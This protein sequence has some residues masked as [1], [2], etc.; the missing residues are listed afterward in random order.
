[1]YVHND[2]NHNLILSEYSGGN[3]YLW[4][5][6][7]RYCLDVGLVYNPGDTDYPT[8]LHTLNKHLETHK[9]SMVFG[10]FNI[11]L[12]RKD[13]R[14]RAYTSLICEC[15][16]KPLNCIKQKH[17][18]R[19]TSKTKTL[20]DHVLTNLKDTDFHIATVD[21]ALFDHKQ[22]FVQ[23]NKHKS[24]PPKRTQY[25]ATDYSKLKNYIKESPFV[26]KDNSYNDLE[27]Y[28]HLSIQNCKVTKVKVSNPPQ[29][30]WINKEVIKDLNYRNRLWYELKLD[31]YNKGLQSKFRTSRSKVRQK[32][33]QT[34]NEF[35]LKQFFA[36]KNNPKKVWSLINTLSR[37][38][39]RSSCVPPKLKHS[40]GY[41]IEP[42]QVCESF[43]NFFSTVGLELAKNIPFR[44]HND[45]I[46]IDSH[47]SN[48]ESKLE[49]FRPCTED[50]IVKIIDKLD[51]KTSAG[52][53]NITTKDIK[54]IG[55][56]MAGHFSKCFNQLFIEGKFPDT[57]K[58]AKVSPIYKSGPRTDPSNYRPISVLP[59]ISKILERIIYSRLDQYLTSINFLT[60]RQY[61]F[62]SRSSTLAATIDL[63]T[64]IK[65][66]IDQRKIV[67]GVFIDL[68]KA[69]DTVNHDLLIRKLVNVGIIGSALDMLKSYLSNRQQVTKIG[70]YRSSPKRISC[71]VPQG[72]I[73]GPLL[74]L[75][76]INSISYIKLNGE[77]T[78]YA[79]DTCLFYHGSCIH[80]ITRLAQEDL[81]LLFNWFQSNLLTINVPKTCYCIFKAKNKIIPTFNKLKIDSKPLT[82]KNSETYLGLRIDKNLNWQVQI[83]HIKTKLSSFLGAIRHS[84]GCL[85]REIRLM[86][87]NSYVKS[88][89]SYLIE[90]WGS[91]SKTKIKELQILQNKIVKV[92]F[93]YD[94]MTSTDIIYKETK[95]MNIYQLYY[96]N[97][98]ILIYKI[99]TKKIHCQIKFI[100]HHKMPRYSLRRHNKLVTP[101]AR[102]NYGKKTITFEGA[103]LFNNLP[104]HVKV[105]DSITI[106]KR[107]LKLYI[108]QN[109]IV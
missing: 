46:Y 70:E 7:D 80:E 60:E 72:S 109:D 104:D 8:F 15:G 96:F 57:L 28:I 65:M 21:S 106:F 108:T 100:R 9:R 61:G 85:P 89:L 67:L 90:I 53:D 30:D 91:A 88:H 55:Y 11:D 3:N 99:L 51:C 47:N 76:Y 39:V 25:Q 2:L 43:N 24:L 17:C 64:N 22:L 93:N 45:N 49:K 4:V 83:N 33:K 34:K 32:I 42:N 59:I 20:I 103:Q 16:Y 68:K 52:I 37:N 84:V 1:M 36:V 31:P 38:V 101:K 66:R 95:I 78:L 10:D 13:R 74:F 56:S 77:L 26:S 92:L 102:T 18:T 44:C 54:C 23:L 12:L 82:E 41:I 14:T 19:E 69:F 62:R 107:R 27:K 79:D 73:L 58:I 71:G 35:Y 6:L 5:H 97:T 87:Y 98:L 105:A 50:E 81:N 40:T 48:P 29:K 75:I 94:F 86:I 63:V